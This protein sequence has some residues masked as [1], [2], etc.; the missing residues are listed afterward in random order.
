ME[1]EEFLIRASLTT[2]ILVI[3]PIAIALYNMSMKALEAG[4]P[5]FLGW[6]SFFVIAASMIYA[7]FFFGSEES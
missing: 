6:I 7:M 1:K 3:I 4:I 5:C 2:R